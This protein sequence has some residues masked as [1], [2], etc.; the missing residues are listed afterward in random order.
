MKSS[1]RTTEKKLEALETK[2]E[3]LNDKFASF[4]ESSRKKLDK[5]LELV[6]GRDQMS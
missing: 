5:L 6:Q 2:L 4:E 1:D 3:D